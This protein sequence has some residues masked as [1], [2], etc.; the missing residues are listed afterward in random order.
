MSGTVLVFGRNALERDLSEG[1]NV[2]C[3]VR[4]ASPVR[5]D[6]GGNTAS[7]VTVDTGRV[8]QRHGHERTFAGTWLADIQQ[9]SFVRR[10]DQTLQ[11][12]RA[13][14]GDDGGVASSASSLSTR[15]TP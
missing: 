15:R 10:R 2:V 11:Y 9:A 5:A 7:S 13:A 3:G 14:D 4:T 1:G 12:E 6:Q 8:T